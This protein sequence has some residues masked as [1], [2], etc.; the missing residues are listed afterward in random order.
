MYWPDRKAEACALRYHREEAGLL[1]S[2]AVSGLTQ[3]PSSLEVVGG[4]GI[5]STVG[6]FGTSFAPVDMVLAIR[7]IR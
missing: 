3:L 1:T 6:M 4:M 7:P 5:P 2:S